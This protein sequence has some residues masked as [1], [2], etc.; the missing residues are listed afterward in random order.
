MWITPIG[1]HVTFKD[2]I[3]FPI[4][5]SVHFALCSWLPGNHLEAQAHDAVLVSKES[6][7][8]AL[9]YSRDFRNAQ[10]V[11]NVGIGP[12][13]PVVLGAAYPAHLKPVTS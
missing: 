7:P 3:F 11:T 5:V 12:T 4:A 1:H 9:G 6:A 10:M 8:V 2:D 13:K